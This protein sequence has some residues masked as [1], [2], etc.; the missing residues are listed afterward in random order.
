[1][2]KARTKASGDKLRT[3]EQEAAAGGA[4]QRYFNAKQKKRKK[5]QRHEKHSSQVVREKTNPTKMK[6]K[7]NQQH[8][9]NT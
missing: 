5:A 4:E 9:F 8:K 3:K 2:R 7:S 6:V 1:M